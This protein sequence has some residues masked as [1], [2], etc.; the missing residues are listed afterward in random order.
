MF[1]IPDP[2]LWI[3]LCLAIG[4]LLVDV[5]L[6]AYIFYRRLSRNRYFQ[7]KDA[8]R[9][10]HAAVVRSFLDLDVS[11][12][13]AISTLRGAS[14]KPER[15]A[16][17]EMLLDGITPA[18]RSMV[19]EALLRLGFVE[20]WA[21]EAFG[22]SRGRQ[23]VAHVV[24]GAPLPA[25]SQKKFQRIRRM[26]LF[27]V[28][29]A[30]A[31][32]ELGQL[33][34][35]FAQ[36]FMEEAQHDPS[37][38]VGRANVA[39]MGQNREPYAVAVLLELMRQAVEGKNGLPVL[40]IKTALVRYSL[41]EL[42]RFAGFLGDPNPRFRFLVVD[43]IREICDNSRFTLGI[44]DFP[45][46]ISRWFLDQAK[47]DS[48]VDVRARSA[49]VIRHFHAPDA[50]VALR[51]LILDPNE[52]V[53]LH[54]VRSCAD[55]YYS[56]L[57][58]DVVQKLADTKWRVR[59]AAV[60]TLAAF[61]REGRTQLAGYFLATTDLYAS[62]QI[63]DEMQ[64]GGI[65]SDLLPALGGDGPDS[66]LMR[67][68][69]SRMVSMGKT[70]L[71]TELLGREIRMGRLTDASPEEQ[72]QAQETAQKAKVQ[73]LDVLAMSPTPQFMITVRS[74]ARRKRDDLQSKARSILQSGIGPGKA[75]PVA[76]GRA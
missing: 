10:K 37:P 65:I 2:I 52:F 58:P 35:E 38:Y 67:K 34:G 26:R 9:R 66:W 23:L 40:S 14:S 33:D 1:R 49:R 44:Q 11:L 43:T 32:S 72:S 12:E 51:D 18:N 28:R 41:T 59:E 63:V 22:W 53:R 71:L 27:C 20:Q 57:I 61:G 62:E 13:H 29:R 75:A 17:R 50:I 47:Q 70:S 7:K 74:L 3:V 45:D 73:L 24:E 60:K 25:F 4:V 68:V 64:R 48:S 36:V 8:T 42:P 55:P 56:A 21:K 69:C 54:A 39:A 19:T 5:I 15:H 46:D 76:A 6:V 30:R 31:V 16:V